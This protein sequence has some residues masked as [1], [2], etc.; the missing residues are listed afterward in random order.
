MDS[1]W[2]R[3]VVGG[4]RRRPGWTRATRVL[5]APTT[6][7]ARPAPLLVPRGARVFVLLRL[8]V[9][10]AAHRD[11]WSA[12]AGPLSLTSS[13]VAFEPTT[14]SGRDATQS[15]RLSTPSRHAACQIACI[16]P[17]AGASVAHVHPAQ[18][19][20]CR[21]HA[22]AKV[23][24]RVCMCS[25]GVCCVLWPLLLHGPCAQAHLLPQRRCGLGH[26]E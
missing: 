5:P 26:I 21:T 10:A 4:R 8:W 7:C 19:R 11:V 15:T 22:D 13:A 17:G 23:F 24:A 20:P 16:H 18:S 3:V 2:N 9:C 25:G 12:D 1:L 6:E 14:S